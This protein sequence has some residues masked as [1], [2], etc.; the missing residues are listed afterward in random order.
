MSAIVLD[1]EQANKNYRGGHRKWRHQ[2]RS[3]FQS[4]NHCCPEQQERDKRV[5]D[6]E[7]GRAQARATVGPAM[8]GQ[9]V[10]QQFRLR[11]SGLLLCG[12]HLAP[13]TVFP[14]E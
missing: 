3:S 8:R 11:F 13:L 9:P 6:L 5:S 1:D 14:A 12:F 2:P 4:D 10:R 7:Q